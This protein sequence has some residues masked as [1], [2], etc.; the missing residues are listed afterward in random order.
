MPWLPFAFTFDSIWCHN[1]MEGSD[2]W[3]F[4]QKRTKSHRK[5]QSK[6]W[7][8][9]SGAFSW[10]CFQFV[11]WLAKL[12][13]Q[14]Y[15]WKNRKPGTQIQ[16]IFGAKIGKILKKVRKVLVMTLK[17]F[18]EAKSLFR[19]QSIRSKIYLLLQTCHLFS[20]TRYQNVS[21]SKKQFC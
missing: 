1:S 4:K 5:K 18:Q 6:V 12:V 9:E 3:K 15:S 13:R 19:T 8:L 21:F 7:C 11:D 16:T 2:H 10:T 17:R 20:S 14:H